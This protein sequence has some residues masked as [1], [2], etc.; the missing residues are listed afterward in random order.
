MFNYSKTVQPH[1]FSSVLTCGYKICNE[2]SSLLGSEYVNTCFILQSTS[3]NT[4]VYFISR[5]PVHFLCIQ[6]YS[7]LS[8][9]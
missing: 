2:F 6:R 1:K 4:N 3:E 7:K 8:K 9:W 5:F